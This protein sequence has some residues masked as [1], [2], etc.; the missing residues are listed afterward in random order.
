M[1]RANR[2]GDRFG[3]FRECKYWLLGP[4]DPRPIPVL[5]ISE[6]GTRPNPETSMKTT[7]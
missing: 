2:P 5:L 4:P 3:E 1:D 6:I 7:S